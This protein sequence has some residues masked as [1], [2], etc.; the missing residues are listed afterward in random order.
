[1]KIL[2]PEWGTLTNDDIDMSKLSELGSVVVL[3]HATREE[4]R[5]ALADA[6]VLLVNKTV[7][8]ADL[9]SKAEN[10]K[11][12][13]EC[14]TGYNNIDL[15]CCRE[16][17]VTVSNVPAYS[18]NAVAQQVF[19]Y[20]LEFY[21]RTHDY[22][23]LVQDNGWV[24]SPWFSRFDYPTEELEGK[25]I[26]LVG[27]G[28]IARKAGRIAAAFGMRVLAY[29][30]TAMKALEN[31][32]NPDATAEAGVHFVSLEDLLAQADVVSVHCPL[33]E[34]S[35]NLFD[36]ETFDK[37]KQGAFFINTARGPIVDEAALAEALTT[38]KLSGA[39]LDVLVQ[40]PMSPDCPLLG[41][42][43]CIITPHVAWAPK[44][45]RQRLVNVVCDNL[46]GFLKGNPQ[47]VVTE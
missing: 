23:A 9:L 41:V 30:R 29:S 10:L 45:T 32:E 25:I 27:Y 14:A 33:N 8:D 22:N 13:G 15:A 1:M 24:E 3:D 38:G 43:N 12:I 18:T 34:A 44:E 17:G 40:E 26:G 21:S 36:K 16:R 37:M 42:K 46:E 4:L 7:V 35:Q 6:D 39:G 5:D 19:G 47:N 28:Q 2:M 11:Y 20:L 31:G